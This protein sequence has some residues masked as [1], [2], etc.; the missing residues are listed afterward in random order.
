V[1]KAIIFL[2][3]F[4]IKAEILAIVIVIIEMQDI[5]F[6]RKNLLIEEKIV[7]KKTPAVTNVDE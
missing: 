5:N 6:K 4:S 7:I 3:S 2:K 1:E